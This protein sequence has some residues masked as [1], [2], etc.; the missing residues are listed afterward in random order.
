[1]DLIIILLAALIGTALYEALR[2]KSGYRYRKFK[3]PE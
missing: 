2:R 1:M 3:R